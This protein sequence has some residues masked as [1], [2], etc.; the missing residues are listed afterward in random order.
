LRV[1]GSVVFLFFV[2]L[3][4]VSYL[5]AVLVTVRQLVDARRQRFEVVAEAEEILREGQ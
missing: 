4:F 2:V 3:G 5:T 1:A